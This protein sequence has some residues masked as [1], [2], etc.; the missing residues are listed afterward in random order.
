MGKFTLSLIVAAA[1]AVTACASDTKPGS[2]DR[3]SA[4][5]RKQWDYESEEARSGGIPKGP[6]VFTG[7]DGAF[8]IEGGGDVDSRDPNKPV[9]VERKRR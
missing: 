2:N 7:K 8:V 3:S 9:R 5:K 4:S 6:G 1:F